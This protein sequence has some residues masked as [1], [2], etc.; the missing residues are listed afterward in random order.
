MTTTLTDAYHAGG[1]DHEH[2]CSGEGRHVP[3]SLAAL[4]ASTDYWV[5][6]PESPAHAEAWARGWLA[7]HAECVA[8]GV[9]R[10]R[11]DAVEDA[12]HQ[13][14]L[15]LDLTDD[16]ELREACRVE[17][18]RYDYT[19]AQVDAWVRQYRESATYP[20]MGR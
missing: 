1:N 13:S 7:A 8:Q 12:A 5:Q 17:F 10:A 11:A 4:V 3:E 20:S 18:A 14:K 15:Q 6:P 9:A 2:V 19:S 16:A